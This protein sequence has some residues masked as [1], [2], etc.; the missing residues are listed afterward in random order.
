MTKKS[1]KP[2]TPFRPLKISVL[3]VSDTRTLA[4][5]T[6]GNALIELLQK[7]GH[8]L[9][10]RLLVK[11]DVYQMRAVV[12][13]WIADQET[14]AILITGGTGFYSRDSTP[15][16]ITPLFDKT[17]EGFGELF[18]Q[19]SYEDIGTSTIQSRAVAGLANQTLIF[20]LPGSTGACRTAWNGILEEQLNSN[21]RPCNF[22]S[23]LLGPYKPPLHEV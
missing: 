15:E 10:K 21:H 12:S 22:V 20:C 16:A 9:N 2:T 5:D 3:T 23:M 8:K 13:Q 11:D 14:H 1:P 17:I 4:E 7:A 19:L 18:R 6:S